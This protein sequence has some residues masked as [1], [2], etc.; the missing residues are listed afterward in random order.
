MIQADLNIILPEVI[1]SL[2]AML[3]LV[4]ATVFFP[5]PPPPTSS[6][7]RVT[8]I[9]KAANP[10]LRYLLEAILGPTY[11][12]W[13]RTT[14]FHRDGAF[15]ATVRRSQ[16]ATKSGPITKPTIIRKDSSVRVLEKPS[17]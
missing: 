17:E 3:A 6:A 16:P 11:G 9:I 12:S 7:L 2:Y 15:R 8:K 13:V 1:L 5:L 10:A 4:G 14:E